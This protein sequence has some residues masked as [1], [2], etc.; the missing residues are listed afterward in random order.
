M[1]QTSST[2]VQRSPLEALLPYWQTIAYGLIVAGVAL[3]IIP[4]VN[5]TIYNFSNPPLCVWAG[6]VGLTFAIAGIVYLIQ[7]RGGR[8]TS[9]MS[10]LDNLRL[11]MLSVLGVAGLFT[12]LFGL[13]LPL[14]QYRYQL[15]GGLEEWRKNADKLTWCILA[16]LSGLVLMFIGLTLG[17][18][19]ERT[20]AGLRRL[21]YGYNAVLT[22]VLL[23]L[24]LTII[25]VLCY[26]PVYPFSKA[27]AA[28]D[29][30]SS[31]IYSLSPATKSLVASIEQ[32]V[33]VYVLMPAS[34]DLSDQVITLL[35]NCRSI[36]DRVSWESVSPQ[37][38]KEKYNE[39]AKKYQIEQNGL[40]ILYGTE[41]NIQNELLSESDL[42][43]VESDPMGRSTKVKFTGEGA[44]YKAL[45]YLSE[46]KAKATV[47]FTQGNGELDFNDRTSRQKDQG[48]GLLI[49]QLGK[50][51]YTLK[52]LPF[53]RVALAEKKGIP[54]DADV[55]V[56]VGPRMQLADEALEALRAYLRK[57][58]GDNKKGKL[59]VMLDVVKRNDGSMVQTGLE[60]LLREFGVNVGNNHVL[61]LPDGKPPGYLDVFMNPPSP[62]GRAFSSEGEQKIF[63]FIDARTVNPVAGEPG[64]EFSAEILA[65]VPMQL[66]VWAEEDL[67]LA[68][69]PQRLLQAM[70]QDRQVLLKKLS[71]KPLSVAVTVTESKPDLL[72]PGHPRPAQNQTPRLVVF[73]DATWVSNELMGESDFT[74]LHTDL[75]TSCLSWLRER[76][77][78]GVGPEAKERGEYTL[79]I[80]DHEVS[81]LK[82]LPTF[83]MLIGVVALGGGVWV[84]RRR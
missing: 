77:T 41:P 19:Y 20:Q 72:P 43:K 35:Q 11:L 46:G 58:H 53:D 8:N 34:S 13:L 61:E 59:I 2:T 63:R 15:A 18:A 10:D 9:G 26:S 23:L 6:A 36:N 55:V 14:V 73:G 52:P 69:T 27:R 31:G 37:L 28:L 5:A 76:P 65:F 47:Y 25:N 60:P 75:M 30:T 64:S 7:P 40:L 68:A 74:L 38:N 50:G 66:G 67:N 33:K 81:R 49:D 70:R 4:I 17:R 79:G 21:M 82:W 12:A 48:L 16:F 57:T 71:P 32:P 29:W 78:L 39:L 42:L 54:D 3:E 45:S 80:T 1:S 44:L 83:L 56:L 62:I 24:I 22:C 51:N 84:V